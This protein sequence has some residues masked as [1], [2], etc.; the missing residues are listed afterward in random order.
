MNIIDILVKA[1]DEAARARQ[2]YPAWP[3]DIA[4]A[5][6]I[7]SEEAG[8]MI[9][10]ANDVRWGQGD[11]TPDDI[12]KEAI[13]TMAM[14]IRLLTETPMFAE[15][16]RKPPAD[17]HTRWLVTGSMGRKT[18]AGIVVVRDGVVADAAPVWA[19]YIGCNVSILMADVELNGWEMRLERAHA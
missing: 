5:V 14:C 18:Y 11:S 9:R 10:A 4:H 16:Q 2:L 7:V 6:A 8:E 17:A 1:Q 12:A 13:Q 19:S 3:N 15:P